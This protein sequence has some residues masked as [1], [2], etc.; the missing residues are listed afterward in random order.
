VCIAVRVLH[1]CAFIV[2]VHVGG[3]ATDAQNRKKFN[4]EEKVTMETICVSK[5]IKD[6]YLKVYKN[7]K[8]YPY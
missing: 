8:V 6:S 1:S 4:D 7:T 2:S 5:L 3:V